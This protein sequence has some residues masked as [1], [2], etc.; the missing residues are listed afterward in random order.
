[1]KTNP[2]LYSDDNKRYH[3]WNYYLRHTYHKKV[4]KVALNAGFTCPNRDGTCGYGGCTFCTAQGS[5]EFAGSK[6]ED[7]MTQF[8]HGKAIMSEK[9]DGLAIPYFQA[10]TNTYAPLNVLKHTFARFLDD[11][12]IPAICIATR[13]DCLE[14]DKIA[15][16][17]ECANHK[18]IW[19]EL[20]LQSI[21]DETAKR[22]N[23]GHTYAQFCD[24]IR[25]LSSSNIRICVHLINGLPYE[26]DAMMME[27]ATA[28]RS[29]P[30]HALKLHMLHIMEQS[31]MGSM[32]KEKPFPLL[33][34]KHYVDIVIRQ[35]E[36][37]PPAIVI[38]RLTGDGRKNTLIAPQ[39]TKNK[40]A[41]LNE[42]DKVMV[43][44]NTWQGRLYKP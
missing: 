11:P 39:W 27:S 9:W 19:I 35:L 36:V 15:Y 30:I 21:H 6:N 43:R 23:R 34:L 17:R 42:I 7:L 22:I 29:L 26:S 16:L 18:D 10:Y 24:C 44:R 5:G 37:L 12:N 25:R 32:Y 3:T 31:A 8:L 1:M 14:N 28:L 4:F 33:T 20:G 13:A 41:V 2:F 40:K 38:Q